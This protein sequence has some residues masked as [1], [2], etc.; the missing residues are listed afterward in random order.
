[1]SRTRRQLSCVRQFMPPWSVRHSSLLHAAGSLVPDGGCLMANTSQACSS[2]QLVGRIEHVHMRKAGGTTV[3][4]NL[5]RACRMSLRPVEGEKQRAASSPDAPADPLLYTSRSLRIDL[6]EQEWSAGFEPLQSLDGT[7]A[8]HVTSIRHPMERL[9][10]AFVFEGGA[11]QCYGGRGAPQGDA[12]I[13]TLQNC[14]KRLRGPMA[15]FAAYINV[16]R[17]LQMSAWASQFRA[18]APLQASLTWAHGTN[19]SALRDRKSEQQLSRRW[20]RAPLFGDSGPAHEAW[21][22][23]RPCGLFSGCRL[24]LANYY[25]RRLL[26]HAEGGAAAA[27][28]GVS[29]HARP[30]RCHAA[31][32]LKLLRRRFGHVVLFGHVDSNDVDGHVAT[33]MSTS[34]GGIISR[35]KAIPTSHGA[36]SSSSARTLQY[37]WPPCCMLRA[38][39]TRPARWSPEGFVHPADGSEPALEASDR[40]IALRAAALRGSVVREHPELWRSLIDE[41]EAD[42]ALWDMLNEEARRMK[43]CG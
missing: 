16:S 27:C 33:S 20:G 34:V 29:V 38:D 12:R 43:P 10:S 42:L 13:K 8:H 6:S 11:P 32:A 28:D 15:S 24:Y 19:E 5:L 4:E 1:V 17:R 3:R 35:A 7:F 22:A 40:L 9:L 36:S 31:E 37:R 14:A 2:N 41:N 30:G 21:H 39:W 23:G 25:V 26:W 18:H